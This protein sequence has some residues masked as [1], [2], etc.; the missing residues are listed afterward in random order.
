[1]TAAHIPDAIKAVPRWIVYKSVPGRGKTDKVPIDH[2]TGRA[3]DA[4][5]P[6][7]WMT[8]DGAMEAAPKHDGIGF[9]FAE[10]DPFA[11]IDLDKCVGPDGDL[12]PWAEQVVDCF[13]SYAEFSPSKTGIHILIRG[14]LPPGIG[15]QV[16][17]QGADG[18]GK[19]EVYDRKRFF[20]VT[21]DRLGEIAE[22]GDRQEELDAFCRARLATTGGV[23]DEPAPANP[24]NLTDDDVI[25]MARTIW[26]CQRFRDLFDRGDISAYLDD[27]SRADMALCNFLA[28]WTGKDAAAVDRLFRRSALMREKWDKK[29][30]NS[31]YGAYTIAKVVG[32]S[33]AAYHPAVE[34]ARATAAGEKA[35]DSPIVVRASTIEPKTVEWLW[36]N[37]VPLGFISIFAGRTSVG[38]SFVTHDIVARVT[39]GG[40]WPDLPGECA[41]V[42]NVLIVSEDSQDTV[43]VPRL[44]AMNA[45]LEK[46]FFMTWKAMA[47]FTLTNTE[48]LGRAVRESGEPSLVIIDPPTNF[49]GEIDDH[50]NT[51]VRAALMGL[52][53]WLEGLPSPIALVLITHVSKGAK[54]VDAIARVIGSVAWMSTARVGH[55]LAPDPDQ[56]GRN[57]FLPSKS[58]I[59]P[60]VD[61]L[62]YRVVPT[63][64]CARVEWLGKVETSADDAMNGEKKKPVTVDAAEW[65]TDQFRQQRS[66]RS[67]DLRRAAEEAGHTGNAI[68]KNPLIKSLPIR[69][70]RNHTA[71]GAVS[72]VWIAK[73]GWPPEKSSESSESSESCPVTPCEK[74]GNPTFGSTGGGPESCP[75][76]KVDPADPKVDPANFRVEGRGP[77]FGSTGGRP[78]SWEKLGLP[79]VYDPTFGTFGTFGSPP[80]GACE[81]DPDPGQALRF[82]AG[83]LQLDQE[84]P[85]PDLVRWGEKKG[86]PESDLLDAAERLGVVRTLDGNDELWRL[87]THL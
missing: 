67:D 73:D 24:N 44:I 72:W 52:V 22:I 18:R 35:D 17:G 20:T 19:I 70:T 38:K 10:G 75:H 12:E 47:R 54:G 74:T 81:G 5:D 59:G 45:D 51:E 49:T 23:T 55:I 80:A 28:F 32:S 33:K 42:G 53:A 76:P 25:H 29:R 4:H 9:V 66:W 71:D 7:I 63:L 6:A 21:G 57:L 61:G 8:F 65:V 34:K 16:N 13:G 62:A 58:N 79:A 3:H 40:E 1:M 31:T 14:H 64:S 78:E 43:L 46:V 87:E 39:T 36:P 11:G 27:P 56:P 2:R 69:K 50:K 26:P 85:R 30:G 77:T 41:P 84:Y 48:M 60:M 15:H 37:R 68:F 82:L 86:I 83:I